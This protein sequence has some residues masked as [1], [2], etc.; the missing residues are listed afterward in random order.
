MQDLETLYQQTA[1]K[2]ET[3]YGP[4]TTAYDL[5]KLAI[6]FVLFGDLASKAH[7]PQ[8]KSPSCLMSLRF[9]KI[10]R[11][12]FA[13]KSNAVLLPRPSRSELVSLLH[14]SLASHNF[15]R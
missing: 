6:S 15:L 11:K 7:Y 2:L 5:F 8:G 12:S 4:S 1:W 14:F 3:K 10:S 9:R 13:S